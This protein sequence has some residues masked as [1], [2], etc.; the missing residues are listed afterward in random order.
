MVALRRLTLADTV[1]LRAT[2]G[3]T[4]ALFLTDRCPVGCGHC[5]VSS[6]VDSPTISDWPLFTGIIDAIAALPSLQAVAITGGEPFAERRGLIHAVQRLAG[7]GKA[8]VLFTSG[9]WARPTTPAWIA[10]VLA[11]TSTVYLS[12]DTF[13]S[14]GLTRSPTPSAPATAAPAATAT[15]GDTTPPATTARGGTTPPATT[16]RNDTTPPATATRGDTTPPA[17][18]ARN[19][20]TPRATTARGG[21]APRAAAGRD[22]AALSFTGWRIGDAVAA[23][24]GAGCRLVL[25][26]LDEPGAAQRA[27]ALSA[28]ADISV[29][30]PLPVGRGAGVFSP[31]APRD[32][33]D[34][35]RCTLLNSPTVRYDGK[36]SACC[37]EEVITGHGPAGLRRDLADP[38]KLAQALLSFRDD[39]VLR[40]MGAYGPAAVQTA[41]TGPFRSICEACWAAHDRVEADPRARLTLTV[42]GGPR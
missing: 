38:A 32:A 3:A 7:A 33:A 18:T 41:V 11:L 12:T 27:R 20:T 29:I 4:L 1:A 35:G 14:S 8:V 22:G 31:R 40:L 10:D 37:N 28:T 13:H 24:E 42:L 30:A 36:V 19:D 25:Q 9:H 15:R 6:K 17:T 39:P 21:T 16:A 23:I 5:S 2:P 34:F 26:V